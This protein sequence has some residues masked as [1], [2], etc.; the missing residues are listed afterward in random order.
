VGTEQLAS[1][2]QGQQK[3]AL[4]EL[5]NQLEPLTNYI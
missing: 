3:Q 1:G 2:M 4:Y 5:D